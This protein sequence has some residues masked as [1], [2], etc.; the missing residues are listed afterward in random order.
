M[1][2]GIRGRG[3][4]WRTPRW[5]PRRRRRRPRTPSSRRVPWTI[6]GTTRTWTTGWWARRRAC[7]GM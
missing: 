5:P 1:P 4:S 2:A 6:S 7:T 3:R